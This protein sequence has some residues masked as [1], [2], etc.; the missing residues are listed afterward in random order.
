RYAER[1]VHGERV[2][3]LPGDGRVRTRTVSPAAKAAERT[4][5]RDV[6]RLRQPDEPLR[7]LRI[8]RPARLPVVHD[9]D[10]ATLHHPLGEAGRGAER[11]G[12]ITERANPDKHAPDCQRPRPK[13]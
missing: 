6:E 9:R 12:E 8:G 13:L 1:K 5:R 11:P 2:S 3:G 4:A 10:I 7:A